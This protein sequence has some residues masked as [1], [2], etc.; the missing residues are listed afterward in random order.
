MGTKT[1]AM[2]AEGFVKY[3]DVLNNASGH[4]LPHAAIIAVIVGTGARIGEVLTMRDRDLFEQDG[5][6]RPNVTRTLEKKR[7]KTPARLTV[8]FPW[9]HLGGPIIRWRAEARKRF[10]TQPDA[11]LFSI[12][13]DGTP[14]HRAS[15]LRN[16]NEFLIAAGMNPRGVGMHGIRKTFLREVYRERIKQGADMMSA[17]RHVQKLAGHARFETTLIYLMD[18]IDESLKDTVN[19]VFRNLLGK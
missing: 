10:L 17:L 9:E 12:R 3:I 11:A 5:T 16:A 14:I 1:H 8:C 13:Y 18:E 7:Q 6:P 2:G 4:L 15:V 19:Q